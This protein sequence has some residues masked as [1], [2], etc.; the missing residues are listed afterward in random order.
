MEDEANAFRVGAA[1]A[2]ARYSAPPFAAAA[3]RIQH[4]AALKPVWRVSMAALLSRAKKDR[5]DYR[6]PEPVSLAADELNGLP[7]N[8]AARDRSQGRNSHRPSGNCETASRGTRLRRVRSRAS[9]PLKR[10]RLASPSSAARSYTP[11]SSSEIGVMERLPIHRAIVA[12]DL[13]REPADYGRRCGFLRRSVRRGCKSLL[14]DMM[15]TAGGS[16]LAMCSSR[17]ATRPMPVIEDEDAR[18][19]RGPARHVHEDRCRRRAASG[20]HAV[21]FD[22]HDTQLRRD[23]PSGCSGSRSDGSWLGASGSV[24]MVPPRPHRRPSTVWDWHVR[25]TRRSRPG[26]R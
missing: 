4:L 11:T 19:G 20:G 14:S 3:S 13:A 5:C 2:G 21:A 24:A 17:L 22:M 7:Q 9:P 18:R 25:W 12:S 26:S 8:G 1:H 10:R 15:R 23:W 16:L 6:Q